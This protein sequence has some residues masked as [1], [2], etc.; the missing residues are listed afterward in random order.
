MDLK[1]KYIKVR[2]NY[3]FDEW[4]VAELSECPYYVVNELIS[5][6]EF[7]TDKLPELNGWSQS[8]CGVIK[9]KPYSEL[10]EPF[11]YKV[12]FLKQNDE[13]PLYFGVEE[14]SCDDYLDCINK[15]Q[16]IK[17]NK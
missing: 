4:F 16:T 7:Y 11:F 2:K 10:D 3:D 8:V 17:L 14:I 1:Q 15:E 9:S 5:H 12:D 13:I 6:L